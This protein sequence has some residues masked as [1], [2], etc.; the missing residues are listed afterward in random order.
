M[1]RPGMPV[2]A[3]QH[4]NMPVMPRPLM[5]PPGP[6]IL[7]SLLPGLG[8]PSV[9][10]AIPN[11]HPQQVPPQ[12]DGQQPHPSSKSAAAALVVQPVPRSYS[13]NTD[14]G[15][16]IKSEDGQ[17]FHLRDHFA[18]EDSSSKALKAE[19]M[20]VAKIKTSLAYSTGSRLAI[21]GPYICYALNEGKL[22]VINM[23]TTG[24]C[25]IRPQQDSTPAHKNKPEIVDLCACDQA[26]NH[27]AMI[28]SD[29]VFHAFVIETSEDGATPQVRT[30]LNFRHPMAGGVGRLFQ[31][32]VWSSLSRLALVDGAT[33]VVIDVNNF[34]ST[35]VTSPPGGLVENVM[36]SAGAMLLNG[37]LSDISDL[38]FSFDQMQL[39]TSSDDGSVRTWS[40]SSGELLSVFE[41]D[42]GRPVSSVHLIKNGTSGTA[43]ECPFVIG[44]DRDATLFLFDKQQNGASS[45]ST[46]PLLQTLDLTIGPEAWHEDPDGAKWIHMYNNVKFELAHGVLL[47]CNTRIRESDINDDSKAQGSLFM[48]RLNAFDVENSSSWRFDW[49]NEVCMPMPI[50]S[51]AARQAPQS[52]L[53]IHAFCVQTNKIQCY[54]LNP[55]L[56]FGPLLAPVKCRA[57]SSLPEVKQES[58]QQVEADSGGLAK[59]LSVS[60]AKS[61]AS[62]TPFDSSGLLSPSALLRAISPTPSNKVEE[63]AQSTVDTET[64][65]GQHP[66]ASSFDGASDEDGQREPA[67]NANIEAPT[68]HRKHPA[69]AS[70]SLSDEAVAALTSKLA[71]GVQGPVQ[72]AFR[73]TFEEVLVPAFEM[74]CAD[75]FAQISRNLSAGLQQHAKQFAQGKTTEA[76][77]AKLSAMD[78]KINKLSV[79][80][81]SVES[82]ASSVKQLAE[83]A[84]AN[85]AAVESQSM[86]ERGTEQS[87]GGNTL[88][89]RE[90]VHGCNNVRE[91]L[92]NNDLQGAFWTAL[93]AQSK[94]LLAWTCK[95]TSPLDVVKHVDQLVLLSLIQQLGTDIT[96]ENAE[97]KLSWLM[98][99]AVEVDL[100]NAQ[101]GPH[102][103]RVFDAVT[104]M[105]EENAKNFDSDLTYDT[106]MSLYRNTAALSKARQGGNVVR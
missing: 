89:A 60:V 21:S 81:K 61:S 80:A 62:A 24:K 34:N 74:A 8:A 58:I 5:Q 10:S 42:N 76:I 19:V 73:E 59:E 33:A 103:P 35:M 40:L 16:H 12:N 37:H 28:L 66:D 78:K 20:T 51:L 46:R 27:F 29:G 86:S 43:D 49:V 91:K 18:T 98:R 100:S 87:A 3:P 15:I 92:Q 44:T 36:A 90:E 77:D 39:V 14:T 45:Q 54:T 105:L 102:V 13:G 64:V 7:T 96:K 65:E 38:A 101:I 99:C 82:L 52:P 1:L 41:P 104:S 70:F 57:I 31:R 84:Q 63:T 9:S 4:Q 69:V 67:S 32:V 97:D 68:S 11:A 93:N 94:E 79:L 23:M 75:M 50:R 88:S 2:M 22:R 47:C 83:A 26:A 30:L 53:N 48:L 55:S 71:V 6:N 17:D 25:L 56:S 106:V 95:Q 85:V 72:S